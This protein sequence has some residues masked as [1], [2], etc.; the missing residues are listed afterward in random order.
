[1]GFDA[2]RRGPDSDENLYF[3]N[4]PAFPKETCNETLHWGKLPFNSEYILVFTWHHYWMVDDF[5]VFHALYARGWEPKILWRQFLVGEFCLVVFMYQEKARWEYFFFIMNEDERQ[6]IYQAKRK[7]WRKEK[8]RDK[9]GQN[10]RSPK[11]NTATGRA[12]LAKACWPGRACGLQ[13]TRK[14]CYKG[15]FDRANPAYKNSDCKRVCTTQQQEGPPKKTVWRQSHQHTLREIC[16]DQ[17]M[18]TAVHLGS[19]SYGSCYLAL[20]KGIRI[21]VKEL[22]VKQLQHENLEEAEARVADDLIYTRCAFWTSSVIIL[23]FP[24]YLGCAPY[25]LIMQ[26]HGNQDGTSYTVSTMLLE[27]W[28]PIT[29]TWTRIIAKTAGASALIHDVMSNNFLLDNRVTIYNTV[30]IDFRKSVPMNG[31]SGPKSLS[32]ECQRQYAREFPHIAPE[33]VGGGKRAKHCQWRF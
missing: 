10:H 8:G 21:I 24:F 26:F 1:M 15:C 31:S 16:S 12:H 9:A 6:H 23:N 27:K 7:A 29:I 3:P 28:S 19:G 5:L 4:Y 2:F 30:V 32:V 14:K 33:I 13:S 17:I 11:S 22:H 25:Y 20:Y 18:R